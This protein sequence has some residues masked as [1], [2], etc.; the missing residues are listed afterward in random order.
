MISGLALFFVPLNILRTAFGYGAGDIPPDW[1]FAA[2]IGVGILLGFAAGFLT[3]LLAKKHRLLLCGIL[4]GLLALENLANIF[5]GPE[6]SPV[7]PYAI[8][9][10]LVTPAVVPGGLLYTKLQNK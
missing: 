1:F 10:F 2:G 7:W 3:A 5:A 4:A 9:L 6:G 8:S